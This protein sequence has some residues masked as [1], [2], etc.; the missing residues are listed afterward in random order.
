MPSPPVHPSEM[1]TIS[2]VTQFPSLYSLAAD[3]AVIG[4]SALSF[5][6]SLRLVSVARISQWLTLVRRSF[7][8]PRP[9]SW[10]LR[11]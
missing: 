8:Q 11:A 6:R 4:T 9:Y 7:V 1:T 5:G 3:T 2:T 10:L